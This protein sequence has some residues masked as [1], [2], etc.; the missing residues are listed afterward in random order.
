MRAL[1]E[2]A[3]SP[4]STHTH[5]PADRPGAS[6]LDGGSSSAS[7]LRGA[8][9]TVLQRFI[10]RHIGTMHAL[11]EILFLLILGAA[12]NLVAF[13]IDLAI[14]FLVVRRASVSQQYNSFLTSY[15]VWAGSSLLLCFLSVACIHF[16]GPSAAGSGIPQMKCLLEGGQNKESLSTRTLI[17]KTLSLV[18][19]LGGGLSIGKEG[20]YVHIS[21]CIAAQLW[22]IPGLKRLGRE[23][24][25][26]RQVLAA[27]CAAGVSATFGAPV[28]GVLFSI[29]V[30]STYFSI[31]HLWKSLFASVCGSLIFRLFRERGSLALFNLTTFSDTGS[32]LYNGEIFAFALLG[33]VCG[34]VG[35]M[36]IHATA[37]LVQLV[38]EMRRWVKENRGAWRRFTTTRTGIWRYAALITE[39]PAEFVPRFLLSRYGY[40]LLVAFS[41]AMFTFPFGFFR[42]S[43]Q[44][45][46][47]ELFG[48]ARFDLDAPWATPS[49]FVNL[50]VYTVCKF[51]FTCVAVSCP[52]SC[53]VFTPVFLIGAAGGRCFG[54]MLNIVSPGQLITPGCYAVVGAAALAASVTRTVSTAVIVFELTGQLNLMLPVLVA[55]LAACGVSNLLNASIYD[56]MMQLNQLPYLKPPTAEA[57]HLTAQDVMDPT[58][59]ALR[60][61]STYM[62]IYQLLSEGDG[63]EYAVLG[64]GEVLLGAV[65]RAALEQMLGQL[66]YPASPRV[67]KGTVIQQI[68]DA[69]RRKQPWL[70]RQ[71]SEGAR[72]SFKKGWVKLKD[73]LK[74]HQQAAASPGA[75]LSAAAMAAGSAH[76]R[77]TCAFSEGAAS[78]WGAREGGGTNEGVTS[79]G[80]ACEGGAS[81]GGTSEGGASEGGTNEG[82]ANDGAASGGAPKPATHRAA[83]EGQ[84]RARSAGA[85][86]VLWATN[87]DTLP[88]S[89][90]Q[91]QQDALQLTVD[92]GINL[93]AGTPGTSKGETSPINWAPAVVLALTPLRQVYMHFSLFATEQAYVTFAGRFIGTIR[94]SQLAEV[95]EHPQYYH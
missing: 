78:E 64:E 3:G 30:T 28:G 73:T 10:W 47:N 19:A 15:L 23:D 40:T 7:S 76:K 14:E 2:T 60:L 70:R 54:E 33:I 58:A 49:L 74:A 84:T 72:K 25:L 91:A 37:S 43:P 52:I 55:V 87:G 81:E 36:F 20:P 41:S 82:A 95:V 11:Q 59:C 77:P 18:F 57:S 93:A 35:S 90:S 6:L 75:G 22:R 4:W 53:G 88:T 80:A 39:R 66:L 38:R 26:R 79:E 29:E 68:R 8:P 31:A 13:T 5:T 21:S 61:P 62:D 67:K 46:C 45:V 17:A 89:L 56:T 12:S 16:I 71:Y 42:S 86:P 44:D 24:E 34:L 85:S 50:L 63:D 92:F 69:I 51:V 48:T 9:P 65:S 1:E 27:G 32:L 94:R 83:G